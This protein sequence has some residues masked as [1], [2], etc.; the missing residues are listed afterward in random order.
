MQDAC[1]MNFVIDLA[2]RG[3]SVAQW[4][5]HRSAECEDLRFNSSWGLRIFSL[6]HARDKTKNIFLCLSAPLSYSV[7][8][9]V[10]SYTVSQDVSYATSDVCLHAHG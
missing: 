3:V 4:L 10:V 7:G 2:R 5:E 9:A 1:H 8:L 6:S